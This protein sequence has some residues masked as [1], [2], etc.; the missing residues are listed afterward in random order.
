M[1]F[2]PDKQHRRSIRLRGHDYSQPALYFVTICTR[3]RECLFGE[4]RNGKMLLNEAG[5]AVLRTW[6]ALPERFAPVETDSFVVMP[7]HVHG[8][9]GLFPVRQA[10]RGAA[11]SAPTSSFTLGRIIRAFKSLS[12]MAANRLL[13]RAGRPL[14]QR[15]YYEHIIRGGRDLDDLREYIQQNPVRWEEDPENPAC[16]SGV[17]G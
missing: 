5:A 10:N 16:A 15:N 3:D 6:N 4:I 2:D 14:W 9:I 8:V 13:H 1:M 17:A 12:A 11:S 7:N